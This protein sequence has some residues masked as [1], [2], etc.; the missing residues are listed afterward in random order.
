MED[1]IKEII[2]F[3]R[4]LLARK[5]SISSIETYCSCLKV[6]YFKCDTEL[7]IEKIKDYIIA[8]IKE[9]SYHKQIVATVRNYYDFVLNIKL[10][11]RELPYPRKQEKIPEVFSIEEMRK[12]I[13]YPKNLKHQVIICLFYNCGFRMSE[14]LYLKPEHINRSRLE[15]MIKGSKGNKDR[16]VPITEKLL[17]LLE[18]Y[19]KE[20]KPTK[21]L[22]NGQHGPLYT[23]SSINQF[24]KYWA[25]K[26]GINKK[27]H[28]HKLRHTFATHLHE[29]GVDLNIINELLGHSDVKTTEIYT[30]TSQAYRKAPSLLSNIDI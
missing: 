16:N 30:K 1:E 26:C 3:K 7:K 18:R 9:R 12:L 2:N 13:Q 4:E 22:F 20:F 28:A 8:N 25:K 14:L 19:Y 24:L 23:E 21:Y 15:I 5:Y 27:I 10:Q 17:N 6:L 29:S 11:L